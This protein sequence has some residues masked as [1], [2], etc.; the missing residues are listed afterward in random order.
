MELNHEKEQV[1]GGASPGIGAARRCWLPQLMRARAARCHLP[2]PPIRAPAL[3]CP[4]PACWPQEQHHRLI[5]G[6]QRDLVE[7]HRRVRALEREVAALSGAAAGAGVDVSAIMRLA[8]AAASQPDLLQL[9]A[10]AEDAA[11]PATAAGQLNGH[12]PHEE[13]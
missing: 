9:Q 11:P 7:E 4:C 1:R 3:P 6:L 8:A 5:H 2:C 13:V 12:Q 10:E